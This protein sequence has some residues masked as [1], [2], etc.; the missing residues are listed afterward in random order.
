[1]ASLAQL[2]TL[3]WLSQKLKHQLPTAAKHWVSFAHVFGWI[4]GYEFTLCEFRHIKL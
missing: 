3:G 1:M 4:L 2:I